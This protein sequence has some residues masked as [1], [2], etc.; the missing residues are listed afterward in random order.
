MLI[1]IYRISQS[2][3]IFKYLH[4]HF[5]GMNE[6]SAQLQS[7]SYPEGTTD[8]VWWRESLLNST[9]VWPSRKAGSEDTLCLTHRTVQK[10]PFHVSHCHQRMP[11]FTQAFTPKISEQ[12]EKSSGVTDSWERRGARESQADFCRC[13]RAALIQQDA[14]QQT[15]ISQSHS[16]STQSLTWATILPQNSSTS[17]LWWYEVITG[18][19]AWKMK[20]LSFTHSVVLQISRTFFHAAQ[21]KAFSR[22]SMLL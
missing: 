9:R 11:I 22:M 4:H 16:Q 18:K 8:K 20:I 2:C 1:N 10:K 15:D 14:I 19:L 21:N 3:I 12:M 17:S 5:R 13:E 7:R 6:Y